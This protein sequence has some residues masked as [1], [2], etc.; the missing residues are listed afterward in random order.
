[1]VFTVV[2]LLLGIALTMRQIRLPRTP[3]V[4]AVVGAICG[5]TGTTTSING[6]PLGM[7][8]VGGS[9]MTT[10]RSTL[11]AFL[12][13]STVFSLFAL[14]VG[15]RFRADTMTLA[16]TLIPGTLAGFALS[17]RLLRTHGHRLAPRPTL[18]VTSGIATAIFIGKEI[19]LR[20]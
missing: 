18:L 7:L 3:A 17:K 12:L 10:I 19:W 4:I 8:M 16:A 1:M 5:I 6:P 11:S 2:V 9:A 15:G 14:Y 13:L 20:S